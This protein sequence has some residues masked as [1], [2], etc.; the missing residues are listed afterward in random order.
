M[1][2]KNPHSSRTSAGE[3][4]S[5]YL[6]NIEEWRLRD[7]QFLCEIAAT[8]SL[9]KAAQRFHLSQ[10]AASRLLSQIERG[11]GTT[12]FERS[13][14]KGMLPTPSGVLAVGRAHGVLADMH[15]LAGELIALKAGA[16]GEL[17]LGTVFFISAQL[18]RDLIVDLVAA[19][20]GLR[21]SVREADTVALVDLLKAQALDVAIARCSP[22]TTGEEVYQQPLFRQQACLVAHPQSAIAIQRTIHA[23]NL[24]AHTWI[25]PPAGSPT[26]LALEAAFLKQQLPAPQP[27][28]ETASSKVIH[29]VV[30]TVVDMVAVVPAEIG[31][32]IAKLGGV[33][34]LPLPFALDV[35]PIGFMC[36]RR[37]LSEPAVNRAR[38]ALAKIAASGIYLG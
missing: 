24:R 4:A 30:A 11:L 2:T 22:G 20:G 38:A 23:E 7:L 32:D 36:L 37:R 9:T 12:L 15:T 6:Q 13:R 33:V 17:R 1:S 21:V 19:P 28:L 29:A 8:Q 35:P 25:L 27:V 5:R 34:N 14:S 31:R 26:R 18:V 16:R 3:L 10:P